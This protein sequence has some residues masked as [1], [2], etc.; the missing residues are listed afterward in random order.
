MEPGI[1][2]EP[3]DGQGEEERAEKTVGAV[4]S[5]D[6][7]KVGAGFFPWQQQV[8]IVVPGDGI[9]QLVLEPCVDKK[10]TAKNQQNKITE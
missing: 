6:D 9:H 8:Y 2:R 1:V 3:G 10:D 5:G 4:L 7:D